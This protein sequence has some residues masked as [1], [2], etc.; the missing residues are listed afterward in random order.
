MAGV[1]VAVPFELFRR[2]VDR[3]DAIVSEFDAIPANVRRLVAELI[4]MRAFDELQAA[5]QGIALRLV[6]GGSYLD[7]SPPA[8]LVHPAPSVAAAKVL[9]QNHGRTKS[10]ELRWAKAS[11]VAENCEF[12]VNEDEHFVKAIVSRHALILAEMSAVRN[13]IA[14]NNAGARDRYAA[15]IRRR[16]GARLNH[17]VPGQLLLSTRF[18][19]VLLAEYLGSCRAIVKDCAKG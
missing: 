15:V 13:R 6:C 3:H 16:Y 7:G 17:I 12:T 19:P 5:L 4:L 1:N 11:Y 8:L 10:R 14:H 9:M 2:C 18:R